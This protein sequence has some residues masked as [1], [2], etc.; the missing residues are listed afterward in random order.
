MSVLE[1]IL[2]DVYFC[3]PYEKLIITKFENSYKVNT[4]FI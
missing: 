2:S 1:F 3:L 4:T